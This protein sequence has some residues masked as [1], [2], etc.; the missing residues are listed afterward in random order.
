ML[1][2]RRSGRDLDAEQ[3]DQT[4][5][6]QNNNDDI[7]TITLGKGNSLPRKNHD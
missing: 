2:L 7:V 5:F 6:D 1:L 4:R 3:I